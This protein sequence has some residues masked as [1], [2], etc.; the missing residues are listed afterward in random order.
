MATIIVTDESF[1]TNVLEKSQAVLVDFWPDH[2]GPCHQI[3]PILEEIS[4]EFGDRL[5]VAKVDIDENP[6][7]P[8]NYGVRSIPT[9]MIFHNG[10]VAA[11]KIGALPKAKLLAWINDTLDALS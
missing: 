11:M 3:A 7:V 10:E 6:E 2:C 1:N 4:D 8:T 9:M 5:T